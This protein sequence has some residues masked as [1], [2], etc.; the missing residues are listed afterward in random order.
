M[1]RVILL[2]VFTAIGKFALGQSI[3][4]F[5]TSQNK[6]NT[7]VWI[8][9]IT[10]GKDKTE[11]KMQ[12]KPDKSDIEIYLYPPHSDQ[13]VILRT[14]EK[15][16][17]LL[18][19]DSIPFYPE[20]ATVLYNE[21]KTF[22]LYYEKIPDY[23]TEVD[24]IERVE[25]FE[26]GFSF[27]NVKLSK[28]KDRRVSLRFNNKSDF[29]K[30]F[31]NKELR[32]PLE[33]FWDIQKKIFTSFKKK[34]SEPRENQSNDTLAI[35]KED[36]LFRAYHLDGEEYGIAIK[37]LDNYFILHSEVIESSILLEVSENQREIKLYGLLNK[38]VIYPIRKE[39]KKVE[40][41]IIQTFWKKQD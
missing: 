37:E 10:I 3:E 15:T 17:S 35:V 5:V 24:V 9:K 28:E 33:G 34:K 13:S 1:K 31:E 27:F 19:A 39:R 25:P 11:V 40:E 30:Y 14:F 12:I 16:Y 41:V 26:S 36:G 23:V 4:A 7:D 38:S 21:T 32:H 6:Y 8:E 2:I 20:K 22:S 29:A 18:D